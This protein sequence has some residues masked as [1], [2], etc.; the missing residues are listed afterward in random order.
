VSLESILD[1]RFAVWA[2]RLFDHGYELLEPVYAYDPGST[3]SIRARRAIAFGE[4]QVGVTIVETRAVGPDPNLGL[5]E[6]GCHLLAASWDARIDLH[7][8]DDGS[9]RFE[10]DRTVHSELPLH[11]H[12]FGHPNDVR[13]AEPTVPA[14]EQWIQRVEDVAFQSF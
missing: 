9:E 3:I 13:W 2:E 7:R 1:A 14:P 5:D 10:V 8:G 6:Q 12:P 11:R 4:P